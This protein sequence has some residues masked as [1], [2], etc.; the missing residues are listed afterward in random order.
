M[1]EAELDALYERCKADPE[2]WSRN[3][4]SGGL[5]A[6]ALSFEMG[7]RALEEK[8]RELSEVIETVRQVYRTDDC[9]GTD[10]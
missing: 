8:R 1:T 7:I 3:V 4:S 9:W 2:Y 6:K 10:D 5:I